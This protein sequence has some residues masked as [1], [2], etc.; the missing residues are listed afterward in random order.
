MQS[1]VA[2]VLARLPQ[3]NTQYSGQWDSKKCIVLL[4][5]KYYLAFYRY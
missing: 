5:M 4:H 3:S 1:V 2:S